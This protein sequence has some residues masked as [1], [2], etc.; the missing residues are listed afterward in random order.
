MALTKDEANLLRQAAENTAV[1]K[2]CVETHSEQI[3]ELFT[4]ARQAEEKLTAVK[5][6]QDTCLESHN[7]SVVQSMI[8]NGI[9]LKATQIMR[10]QIVACAVIGIAS[11][12]TSVYIS[13]SL[14]SRT[15]RKIEH[16]QASKAEHN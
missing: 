9:A 12:V 5:T 11:I 1:I 10:Y 8:S 7:P 15:E 4:R 6:R 2:S 14:S 3:R 13:T 16:I